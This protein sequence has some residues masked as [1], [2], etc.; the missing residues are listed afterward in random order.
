MC[1]KRVVESRPFSPDYRM[2]AAI[3]NN[4]VKSKQK[5]PVCGL[6]LCE[7]KKVHEM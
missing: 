4:V 5:K 1:N 2:H 7:W 3:F 6:A